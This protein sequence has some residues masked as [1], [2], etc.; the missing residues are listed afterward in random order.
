MRIMF[1]HLFFISEASFFH[2]LSRHSLQK[3][4]FLPG[5]SPLKHYF[6]AYGG[7]YF[8]KKLMFQRTDFGLKHHFQT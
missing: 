6:S 1:R 2:K 3:M 8:S 4:M 7:V 5:F